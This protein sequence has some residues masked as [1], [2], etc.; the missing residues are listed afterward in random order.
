MTS[1]IGGIT[2]VDGTPTHVCFWPVR[3]ETPSVA[4]LPATSALQR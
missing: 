2:E 1:G 3:M 4:Y